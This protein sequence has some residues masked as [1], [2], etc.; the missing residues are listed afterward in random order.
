V[1]NFVDDVNIFHMILLGVGGR[2]FDRTMP[3]RENSLYISIHDIFVTCVT[4]CCGEMSS[5][6]NHRAAYGKLTSREKR[7]Y[8]AHAMGTD[9]RYLSKPEK[10]TK[11]ILRNMRLWDRPSAK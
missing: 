8:K 6:R 2:I 4:T 10:H 9:K 7:L 5:I 11:F 1:W 3:D